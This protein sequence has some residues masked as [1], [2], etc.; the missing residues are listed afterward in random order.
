M[1]L[2][3]NY[4]NAFDRAQ[5]QIDGRVR[6]GRDIMI[7]GKDI[8]IGCV[9]VG[10]LAAEDLFT[11][12]ADTGVKNLRVVS[13]PIDFRKRSQMPPQ[14]VLPTWSSNLYAQI[15]TALKELPM[16]AR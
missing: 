15:Q 12:A 2:R 16:A 13:S 14:V 9:A 7:H 4:P 8:S 11:L 3:V 5:A 10:D 6:L 1:S